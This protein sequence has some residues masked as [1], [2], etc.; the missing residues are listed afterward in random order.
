M[1]APVSMAD[2]L[3]NQIITLLQANS[4]FDEIRVFD[5]EERAVVPNSHLPLMVISITGQEEVLQLQGEIGP[6][7]GIIK[8]TYTGYIS[9]EIRVADKANIGSDRVA[10]RG[11]KGSIRTYLDTASDVLE[12]YPRLS[13]YVFGGETVRSLSRTQ[14]DYFIQERNSN[15][16]NRGLFGF[17]IETHKERG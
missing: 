11:S 5:T 8:Y 13:N 7:S 1:D 17:Q 9:C 14:K 16:F 6:E 15:L 12:Q 10:L 4:V 2:G 3:E